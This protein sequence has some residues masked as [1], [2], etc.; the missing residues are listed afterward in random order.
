MA[1]RNP[2]S[3]KLP[4]K[5]ASDSLVIAS[6]PKTQIRPTKMNIGDNAASVKTPQLGL[7]APPPPAL[8][9]SL[10]KPDPSPE[11]ATTDSKLTSAFSMVSS[12]GALSAGMLIKHAHYRDM[13]QECLDQHRA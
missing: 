11:P 9:P 8:I 2:E 10:P 1:G 7:L 12:I 13:V 6:P 4:S 5:V 3:L